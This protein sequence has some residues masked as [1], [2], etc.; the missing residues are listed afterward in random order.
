MVAMSKIQPNAPVFRQQ[1][2]AG[3]WRVYLQ[4]V[5]SKLAGSTIQIGQLTF[6]STGQL[7]GGTLQDAGG[8]LTTL[9][10][11]SL[12]VHGNGSVIGSLHAGALT[13]P[14]VDRYTFKGT[15]R[16]ARDL[17]TGVV[18]ADLDG[19]TTAHHGLV[20][21]VREVGVV[22]LGQTAYVVRE[23]LPAAVTVRRDGDRTGTATVAYSLGGTAG[24]GDYRISPPSPL[25]FTA[26]VASRVV[27]ITTVGDTVNQ[28]DRTV[29]LSFTGASGAFVGDPA[30]AV[31]TI[32]DDD[33]PG[34]VGFA[35]ASAAITV[36]ETGLATLR[37][38]RT[39]GIAGGVV[40]T[41]RTVD[42]SARA[43]VDYAARNGS[44]TFGPGQTTQTVTVPI[45]ANELV[46][47]DRTFTVELLAISPDGG[48][49]G[50]P[51][52][53]S[54]TIRDNDLGGVVR[55]LAPAASVLEG[56]AVVLRLT[57]AG[58]AGG[59]VSV[60]WSTLDGTAQAAGGDYTGA[61]GTLTFGPRETTKEITVQSLADS[62]I[63]GDETFQVR[64]ENP[65]GL[66]VG[67]VS[68]A[69]V[70]IQE[71]LLNF[72]SAAYTVNEAM[73]SATIQVAR[74]GPATGVATVRYSTQPTSAA[75]GEDYT[76]VS[77]VLT[78][79][80][81]VRLAS[82]T[83]PLLPDTAAESPETVLLRLS[84]PSAPAQLGRQHTATLTV[85]DNDTAGRFQLSAAAYSA[86][87]KAG[88]VTITVKR[89][90][91]AGGVTV[92]YATAAVP[93]SA[94]PGVDFLS[95]QGTLTF[96]PNETTKAFAVPILNDSLDE[97]NETFLVQLEGPNIGAPPTSA[98]VTI[99]DDDVPGTLAFRAATATVAETAGV[100]LVVVARTGGAAGG[101][102]VDYATAGGSAAAGSDYTAAAGTLTFHAGE[103][104]KT[105]AIAIADDPEREGSETFTLTL[106]NPGGGA[107]LGPARLTVVTITDDE[108]GPTVQFKAEALGVVEN[109]GPAAVVITRTGSTL[110][111]QSV[112]VRTTT[113]GT[114]PPAHFGAVDR[115]VT[116]LAGQTMTTVPVPI[117]DDAA[118]DGDR[119]VV[120]ELADAAT[121]SGSLSLGAPRVTVLTIRDDDS[122]LRFR[123]DATTVE[124]TAATLTVDRV[125]ST[126]GRAT[127]RYATASGT[128]VAPGDYAAR[129]GMLAFAPGVASLAVPLATVND[130]LAEGN[131]SF[132]VTLSQPTGAVLGVQ[133]TAAVTIQDNDAVG[134]VQFDPAGFSVLEG[135]TATIV[136]TRTGG[137]AGPLTVGYET[138]EG[139]GAGAA[140]A[141]V[142][143]LAR[144]GTLTFAAGAVRQTFTISTRQ[145]TA[146]EGPESLGLRL[147]VPPGSAAV[148]GTAAFVSL[149]IVDDD[150]PR[151]QFMAPAA[152]VAEAAGSV[153]LTVQRL[154]PSRGTD[155]VSYGLTGLTATAGADF[156]ATGGT[157]T[158]PPGVATRLIT[159]PVVADTTSEPAETFRVTLS[160]PS[161]D[162][163][164]G[165]TPEATVT[166]TDNDPAGTARFAATSYA[167]DEGEPVTLVVTR[168]GGVAG[169]VTVAYATANGSAQAGTD[170]TPVG[171]VLTFAA[172]ETSRTIVVQTLADAETENT[173]FFDLLLS[174]PAGGLGLDAPVS[175]RVWIIDGQQTVQFDRVLYSVI[176]GGAATIT[177]TRTGVPAG[178]VTASVDVGGSAQH[179]VDYSGPLPGLLEVV[180][181]PGVTAQSFLV[182]SLPDT[183]IEPGGDTVRLELLGVTGAA[184]GGPSA[185]QLFIFDNER[186][187]LAVTSV[188]GPLQAANGL[189]MTV[190]ASLVNESGAPAPASRLGVF[191]S[192]SD[193]T[194]GAGTLLGFVPTPGVPARGSVTVTGAVPVPV[195]VSAGSYFLSAVADAPGMVG[196]ELEG[197][198]GFTSSRQVGVVQFLPDLVVTG[199]PSPGNTLSGKLVSAPLHVRNAGPV[200]SGPFRVGVF[201][202]PGPSP[203]GGLLLATRDVASLAPGSGMD[204]PLSLSVPDDVAQGLYFV[205]GQADLA[206]AVVESEEGNN[207]LASAVPF[208]VTRNLTKLRSV[209]AAFSTAAASPSCSANLA[210]LTLNLAGTLSLAT[211]TGTTGQGTIVLSGPVPGGTVTFRGAFNATVN[212]DETVDISFTATVS[213]AITGTATATGTGTIADNVV[214][215]TITDGLLTRTTAPG[216][217]CPFTGTLTAA[218]QPVLFFSLLHFADGGGFDGVTTPA[219]SYP[220]AITDFSL[221][222]AAVFDSPLS[223]ATVTFTGPPGSGVTGVPAERRVSV[224]AGSFYETDTIPVLGQDLVGAWTVR[225]RGVDRTF[226]VTDPQTEQRFVAML[227]T[228]GLNAAQTHVVSVSWVFK[229]PTTG[230][231]VPAP[232]FADAIQVEF[233]GIGID[234]ASPDF[235]RTV[236]SHT[237]P[238][239][240]PVA[241]LRFLYISFKDTV[242]GHFYVTTYTP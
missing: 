128:A 111:G 43:G 165:A 195:G 237:L 139:V 48:S 118:I 215:A 242:T 22:A 79:G 171:G 194:P 82:F 148:L 60:G 181:P 220:L 203:S 77:G 160:D 90:G 222:L 238:T 16:A 4:R 200:A 45:L 91:N 58:G 52:T 176:E 10:S 175:S 17:I 153:K 180:F 122:A 186:P 158:F 147:T 149:V 137:A 47:G 108:T 87:E 210:G 119:T 20:T 6:R 211:Q 83:V 65:A 86:A 208:Q 11:G 8:T 39:L 37:L 36:A 214:A 117:N 198:N 71:Q 100:A 174:A 96:G 189:P 7:D 221:G 19:R 101:V 233:T 173:Q 227:P 129:T 133:P 232:D 5:E 28:G 146:L 140:G 63:E 32:A 93:G 168:T 72:T 26:G 74:T 98:V 241:S 75:A 193:D 76:T 162:T 92:D 13:S 219:P 44:V 235:P 69:T 167:V 150:Q 30:A 240:L 56:G 110:A 187:D 53:A 123:S 51:S 42:G 144:T 177:L 85:A 207:A 229:N 105:L 217:S 106:S 226:T 84:E 73:A 196:E 55:L 190:S 59:N 178:T 192:P 202:S 125:G 88:S 132:T 115:I 3:P 212:L 127:V 27:T 89:V 24:P 15:M 80:N 182:R 134:T 188:T 2:L 145:D 151:F 54:V 206:G 99:V 213:G 57:R 112:R 23:G 163:G 143:Y 201:L 95:A 46:D 124:G 68:A 66:T 116:F 185:T 38:Q 114:A 120:L 231:T 12:I 109:G 97:P 197:N 102:T 218:G 104:A 18:T 234:Y 1:D 154:G 166:I 164:L 179:G 157:L 228:V 239:P 29:T 136:V 33:V 156:D 172:G 70:T 204:L 141:S 209:S 81:N 107:V 34:I 135:G 170:F 230:A 113:A 138:V 49:L 40:V 223:P 35:P 184:I 103:V 169:P 121:P 67:V 161:G 225:Y 236:S 199:V 216:G 131:E 9:T 64:L 142:D 130:T 224:T 159:V 50:D 183:V 191:L 205:V 31:V 61:S 94:V 14:T 25:T 152:T 21:L 126:L 41:F 155:T 62:V 78:F